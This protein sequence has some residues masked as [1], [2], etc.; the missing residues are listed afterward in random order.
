M[1]KLENKKNILENKNKIPSLG[2]EKNILLQMLGGN[3]LS[4]EFLENR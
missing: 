1:K 4:C 3:I 2:H